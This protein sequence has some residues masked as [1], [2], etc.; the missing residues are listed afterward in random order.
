MVKEDIFRGLKN[1]DRVL[2]RNGGE[3]STDKAFTYLSG[4]VGGLFENSSVIAS[5]DSIKLYVFSL[6]EQTAKATGLDVVVAG[7]QKQMDENIQKDLKGIRKIGLNFESLTVNL[8]KETEKLLLG[9]EFFDISRNIMEA[10]MIKSSEEISR[11]Q[12][13]AKISSEIYSG[14]LTSL[15]EGMKETEVAALM[16]YR[17][18]QAGASGVGFDTIVCFGENSAEPH[19]SPGDR[20]LKKGD[21]VLTDYGAKYRDYTA[22]TTRTAVFGKAT[23]EQKEIYSTVYKA[24]SESMHMIKPGINGKLVNQKSYDIIDS[25][26]YKGRLMHGVGHGIGLDVHDHQAFGSSDFTLKENMAVTVEPGIYIPG[27][28]G[29]RIED[30]VLVTKTGFKLLTKAPLAELPEA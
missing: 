13:A 19:H 5:R 4:A 1:D 30:D 27:Y 20:K 28:G 29:V 9:V 16:N 3:G 24:Q 22:D 8:F 14:I 2:I 15:K 11:L 25:T 26:K 23:A 17:M 21:Y 7:S 10:R 12:E 18:M 6:E